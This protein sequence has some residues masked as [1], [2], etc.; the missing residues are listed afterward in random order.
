MAT[1]T[2]PCPYCGADVEWHGEVV[3]TCPYC[4]TAFTKG[5]E[6]GEHLMGSV[7]YDPGSIFDVFKRW[8]LRIPET[9]NDF[10]EAARLGTCRLEFHPYW[11]YVVRG[12]FRCG[13]PYAFLLPSMPTLLPPGE[14][15]ALAGGL[16]EASVVVTIPACRRDREGPLGRIKLSPAGKVYFSYRRVA[17]AGGALINPDVPPEEADGE[18]L[19]AAAEYVG[20]VLTR[21]YG[22]PTPAEPAEVKEFT[23][24]LVHHP[25]YSCTYEYQGR[26]YRFL[27][28]ASDSRILHAEIPVE[29]K[30]RY[31]ASAA[32][33]VSFGLAVSALL[34]AGA[35][36]VF[37]L[38]SATGL[39]ATGLYCIYRA[40]RRTI[41]KREF[42]AT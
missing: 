1:R 2:L 15:F 3:L 28:D 41:V 7:N 23:R 31:A 29:A 21:R 40:A 19:A 14:S 6:I 4:G 5:G 38:V 35:A 30:F 13:E 9:P 16:E 12:A 24:R 33:A 34:A 27:A 22:R 20:E 37:S 42:Y 25:V 10:V 17:Q 8:A 36:P 18:A 11:V 39:S 32:A 26:T